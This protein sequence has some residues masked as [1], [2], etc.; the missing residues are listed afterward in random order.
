[1]TKASGAPGAVHVVLQG[2]GGVGKSLVAATLMQYLRDT[3]GVERVAGIDTDPSNQT[4]V[5]YKELA[6]RHLP[7]LGENT[8]RVDEGK[9]DELVKWIVDEPAKTFVIDTG[10]TSFLPFSNYII[11]NSIL[12]LLR[13]EGRTVRMHTVITGGQALLETVDGFAALAKSLH[14]RSLVVWLNEFFGPIQRDGK[15]FDQ[16]KAY[17]ANADK[18][19][20]FVRWT[21]RN[22]DT[23]GR[24]MRE[25]LQSRL[26]LREAID[27]PTSNIVSKQ[28]YKIVRD[29][30]WQ[31]LGQIEG[32]STAREAIAA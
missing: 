9:F 12:D 17:Q 26:T 16:F 2:K 4:L 25:L 31:Q 5:G 27:S 7:I 8:S 29:D 14:D 21:A 18:V 20:G 23:F 28:R 32:L 11:E 3:L 24:D 22:P 6:A 30:L 1:M 13:A 15:A 19:L 10:A